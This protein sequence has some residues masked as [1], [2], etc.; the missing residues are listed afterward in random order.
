M[1]LKTV[2]FADWFD[3]EH[4]ET[5]T[6]NNTSPGQWRVDISE[7]C[8]SSKNPFWEI[9]Y[10]EGQNS[11]GNIVIWAF[12]EQILLDQLLAGKCQDELASWL[13]ELG[14]PKHDAGS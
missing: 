12:I 3:Q 14:A 7:S 5:T 2:F 8:A 1:Y 6:S 9:E 13:D 11:K 10:F 4:L